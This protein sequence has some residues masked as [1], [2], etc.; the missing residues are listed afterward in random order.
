V[1][2][3]YDR[4][5]LAGN[6]IAYYRLDGNNVNDL[7]ARNHDG[8]YVGMPTT[9]TLPNGEAATVFDGFSQYAEVPDVDHL[10]I[11]A[12][13]KLTLEA[14]IRPDAL[15]FSKQEGS[16]YVHWMGKGVGQGEDGQQEYAS[17]MYSKLAF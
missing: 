1:L 3:D 15:E 8:H 16:G 7:S 13:G 4:T 2:S 5:V 10:S 6:P 9:T 14:W 17:R 12:T 11:T